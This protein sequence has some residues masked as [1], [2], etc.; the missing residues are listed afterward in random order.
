ME[1]MDRI[2]DLS[3]EDQPREKAIKLGIKNLTSSELL[4]LIINTGVKNCN[5]LE[6]SK[7]LLRKHENLLNLS[8]LNYQELIN[9][10]GLNKAKIY[11][12]AACFELANRIN[13][14]VNNSL[15][16]ANYNPNRIAKEF[17]LKFVSDVEILYVICY[18]RTSRVK[19]LE[20]LNSNKYHVSLI[21]DSLVNK[22]CEND[23][24]YVV[25]VHNHK[26]NI[27]PSNDDIINTLFLSN[28][29]KRKKVTLVD[30]VIVSKT[31][32][33]SFRESSLI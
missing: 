10:K 16:I 32:Y 28:I 15:S 21:S 2:K 33:F 7:N 23:I 6:I 8:C 26:D 20:Y 13:A 31:N 22:I 4:A 5:A 11:R 18:S 1:I 17:Y 27:D 9:V 19:V 30:H 24:K 12:L 14:E 29:L 3:I 25:L